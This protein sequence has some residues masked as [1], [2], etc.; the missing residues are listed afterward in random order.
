MVKGKTLLIYFRDTSF[1]ILLGNNFIQIF[2]KYTQDN[3]RK[4][5]IFITN[6]GSEIL[7]LCS[8]KTFNKTMPIRFCNKL[9][10]FDVKLIHL[11][12]QDKKKFSKPFDF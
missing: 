3:N 12:M 6:Y 10:D 4:I 11:K 8:D 5:L 9:G 1:D 2:S 7:V